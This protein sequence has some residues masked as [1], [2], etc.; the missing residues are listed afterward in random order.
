LD[1]EL[2]ITCPLGELNSQLADWIGD[3]VKRLHSSDY[4]L[5]SGNWTPISRAIMSSTVA[6]EAID[7]FECD[8]AYRSTNSYASLIR[9]VECGKPM[10]RQQVL[11]DRRE[12]ID[13]YF[14]RF[15][16]LFRSIQK[17]GVLS[18]KQLCDRGMAVP[19][20]RNVGV[21]IG[22]DGR[23]YRLPGGQHR[24]AIAK[25]LGL[26]SMPV[27]VRVLHTD[28]LR[29]IINKSGLHPTEALRVGIDLTFRTPIRFGKTDNS[30]PEKQS[31]TGSQGDMKYD[32]R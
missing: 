18:Y 14:D 8:L 1:D 31:E 27:E 26:P 17:D 3:G 13:L 21:A 11:L 30:V 6:R 23:I 2:V 29:A 22:C 25:I 5:G 4:F 20:E 12:L 9:A 10:R 32:V 16:A 7:L 24:T 15:V 28:W 19:G